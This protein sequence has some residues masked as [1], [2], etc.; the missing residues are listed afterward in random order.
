MQEFARPMWPNWPAA[1]AESA[2]PNGLY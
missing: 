1:A 2:A